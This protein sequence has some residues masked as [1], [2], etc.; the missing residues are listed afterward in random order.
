MLKSEEDNVQIVSS[1][2]QKKLSLPK[3]PD[4]AAYFNQQ[5]NYYNLTVVEGIFKSTL[6][7]NNVFSYLWAE[8]D[9]PKDS[10]FSETIDTVRLF[11]DGCGGQNKN[12]VMMSMSRYWLALEA[13]VHIT[14]VEFVFPIVRHS[15][16]PPNRIFGLIE[17]ETIKI[18]VKISKEEYENVIQQDST[19]RKIGRDWRIFDW[20]AETKKFTEFLD[21]GTSNL[22]HRKDLFSQ[23]LNLLELNGDKSSIH[24]LFKK[25]YGDDWRQDPQLEFYKIIDQRGS[26]TE[27]TQE[28]SDHNLSVEDNDMKI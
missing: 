20:K 28:E 11:A 22:I 2:C 10:S 25:H 8:T 26:A 19:I 1:D 13:P 7:L 5:I 17:K 14:T 12:P 23:K 4:Q 21:N 15:F 16:I 6:T 24:S 9:S 18:S 3:L 27:E